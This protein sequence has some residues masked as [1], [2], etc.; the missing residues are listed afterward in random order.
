MG[1]IRH[2]D[3]AVRILDRATQDVYKRQVYTFCGDGSFLMGHSELYTALQEA[4]EVKKVK[5]FAN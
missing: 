1:M 2:G 3:H 4:R 5:R